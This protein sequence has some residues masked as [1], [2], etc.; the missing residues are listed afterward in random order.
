MASA[1]LIPIG[2]TAPGFYGLNTQ[3]TPTSPNTA[4]ALMA[5]NCVIDSYGRIGARKGWTPVNAS[6]ATLGSN[7][8]TAL[9]EYVKNDGSTVQISIGNKSV[10]TGTSTLTAAYTDATWTDNNWK[11]VNFNNKAYF[12][13]RGHDPLY[14]DGTTLAKL[15]AHAGYTGTVPTAN[16]VLS[17]FGRL[18]VAD[19]ST[20]KVTVT[21][22]DTLA[23]HLWTAGASGSLN[24]HNVF[25]NGTDQIVALAAF[26]GFLVILCK[27]CVL[28]YQGA[29]APG[30]MTLYD[31]IDGIGCMGRDTVQ[32]T[33]TDLV[34][35]SNRGLIS[36]GRLIQEKS[37]PI[38]E[39]SK[40]VRDELISSMSNETNKEDIKSVY[41]HKDGFYLLTM[42]VNDKVY[43]FDT[44]FKL[45]DGSLRVT[46]WSGQT[47][48]AFCYTREDV[49]YMGKAGYI[50][51]Y[52]G[53][54]DNGST[55]L[56]SYFTNHMD[57]GNLAQIKMLKK[58]N[59]IIV[60]G[61]GSTIR[62]KWIVDFAYQTISSM[63]A[64]GIASASEYNVSEYGIAEYNTG[65]I[66][67]INQQ[68]GG[69][70]C[71]FQIGIEAV[72]NGNSLSIQNLTTY[73]KAGR[74]I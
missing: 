50:G 69:A 60:G 55:Y 22:S 61:G 16:E 17:A 38:T 12:F 20:D 23:G 21:W 8:V 41:S 54:T 59:V 25:P 14:Y 71:T 29:S 53:Y 58:L 30:S 9:H 64:P 19:T 24:L 36:L 57:A 63:N 31:T 52:F 27:F 34:F 13:Q 49:L 15:S 65:N 10:F 43:C 73:Y 18:W 5:D 32:D 35:L 72:I 4:Y 67:R 51:K 44:R 11:V 42:P 74:A 33:G 70:G 6:N 2:V 47:P 56:M 28:I 37:A 45:E 66:T 62:F 1:Q 26:N 46:T 68:L 3:D 7:P 39:L 48:T 40:N